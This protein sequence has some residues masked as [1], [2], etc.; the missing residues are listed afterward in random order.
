MIKTITKTEY[1]ALIGLREVAK[2]QYRILEQ[3][4]KQAAE[5]VGEEADGLGHSSD[6]LAGGRDLD[7]ML[8]IL[9]ITV[10]SVTPD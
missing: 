10:R 9:K 6:F 8:D 7:D 3:L 1:S 4:E 5:I 2:L